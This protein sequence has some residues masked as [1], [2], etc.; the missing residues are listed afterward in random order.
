MV[1]PRV[2]VNL[3]WL[4][5]GAAVGAEEYS[6]RVLRSML[7]VESS[8][9]DVVLLCNRRFPEAHPDLALG[10]ETVVAPI[11]GRSRAIRIATESTWLRARAAGVHLVHQL[12]NVVPWVSSRP[13]VLTIHDLRPLE[14]PETIGRWHGA[15]LRSRFGPSVRHAAMISTPSDFVRATVIERLGADPDR[16]R[17]VSAPVFPPITAERLEPPVGR[18]FF[19][20]PAKTL[21]HKN[22]T[23]LLEAFAR[24]VAQRPDALLVLTGPIGPAESSIGTAIARLGLTE[25]VWRLGRVPPG[26][27]DALFR[28]AT[29]LTYPST[30]EGFGLPV[31]EAMTRGCPVIASDVTALPEVVG[32]A[33]LLV[34]PRDADA[35]ARAMLQLLSDEG[36]RTRLAQLGRVRVAAWSPRKTAHDQLEVYR[37]AVERG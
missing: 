20:Y 4:I 16:V 28:E 1:R 10:F 31:V 12:N 2:G 24:V 30:Y 27:L 17:V 26:R 11:D 19:L 6:V 5:P 34:D 25:H 36:A 23:M 18:P 35:W 14:H 13:V 21:P 15:Y 3:L 9:I 7:E 29:A 8:A 37:L 33:G 22:H 32:E